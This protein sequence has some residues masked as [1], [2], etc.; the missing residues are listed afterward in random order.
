MADR[1]EVRCVNKTDRTSAHERIH[2]IGGINPNGGRWKLGET[3]A[4]AGI[5]RGQWSFYVERPA[6]HKV[7]VVVATRLGKKY[8]KTTAD[9]EQPDNLLSLPECPA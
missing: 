5:E 3:A 9:G 4:I 7:D 6:G 2:N 1:V 8:L